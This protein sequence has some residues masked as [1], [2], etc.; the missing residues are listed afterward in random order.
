MSNNKETALTPNQIKAAMCMKLI[1]KL[2]DEMPYM[3]QLETREEPGKKIF[4]E[5]VEGYVCDAFNLT[6]H[7][8]NNKKGSDA[9][10]PYKENNRKIKIEIKEVTNSA[11]KINYTQS[12]K[13]EFGY[14][15]AVAL[16]NK[17]F[18]IKEI[19]VFPKKVVENKNN[20]REN[21]FRC[22]KKLLWKSH[23][24]FNEDGEWQKIPIKES[25]GDTI[26][27]EF[28]LKQCKKVTKATYE[29]SAPNKKKIEIK[30]V[31]NSA[32]TIKYTKSGKVEFDYLIAVKSDNNGFSIKEIAVFPKNVVENRNNRGNKNDFRCHKKPLWGKHLYFQNGERKKD[33]EKAFE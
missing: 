32:P 11:P 33:P 6:Q 30:D 13:V 12:G 4:S 14:L 17:D 7:K 3:R 26:S 31:T 24:Y 16:N 9:W 23:L 20:R 18:S 10:T 19:A 5:Y 21:Y 2:R 1:A 22:H 25:F 15:I 8:K 29:A 28:N 27:E